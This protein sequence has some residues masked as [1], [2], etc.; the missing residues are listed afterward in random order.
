MDVFGSFTEGQGM[1]VRT[2]KLGESGVMR[3][4]L[5]VGDV[6]VKTPLSW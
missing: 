1:D 2:V 6:G 3:L 5:S 4:N